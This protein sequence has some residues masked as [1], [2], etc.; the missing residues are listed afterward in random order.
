[1]GSELIAF[2]VLDV[3]RFDSDPIDKLLL[4]EQTVI[5]WTENSL[6]W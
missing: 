1:M 6:I 3:P 4:L 5:Y 2:N